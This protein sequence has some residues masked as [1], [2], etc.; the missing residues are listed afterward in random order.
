MKIF[1]PLRTTVYETDDPGN[2]LGGKIRNSDNKVSSGV[3]Y[4]ICDVF[5]PRISGIRDQNACRILFMFMLKDM[6]EKLQ[7]RTRILA[8]ALLITWIAISNQAFTQTPDENYLAGCAGLIK[9]D[10]R[11]AAEDFSYAITRNN[12]DEQLFIKEVKRI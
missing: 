2:N 5:E 9:G 12:A 11:K 10:Y 4:Y 1:K 7:N 3:Y 8:F 6:Q